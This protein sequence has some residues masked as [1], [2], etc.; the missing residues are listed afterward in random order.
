[1]NVPVIELPRILE[2]DE[3]AAA[4]AAY[5]DYLARHQANDAH[6]PCAFCG[7]RPTGAVGPW[8]RVLVALRMRRR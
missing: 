7:N 8:A 5:R 1:M 6:C 2:G 3:K 4:V